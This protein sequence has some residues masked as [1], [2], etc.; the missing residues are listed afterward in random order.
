MQKTKTYI[1]HGSVPW[2]LCAVLFLWS[3]V[4]IIRKKYIKSANK[5]RK[6]AALPL[7]KGTAGPLVSIRYAAKAELDKQRTGNDN[8]Q[9]EEHQNRT[10]R[11]EAWNCTH[12]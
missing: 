4:R 3:S 5:K 6:K 12:V 7:L 11:C 8:E 9:Y 10:G 2:G 1:K